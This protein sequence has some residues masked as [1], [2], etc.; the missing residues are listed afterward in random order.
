SLTKCI[1]EIRQ[2]LGPGLRGSLRTLVGRGYML[3]GWRSDD[4]GRLLSGHRGEG[5]GRLPEAR[6]LVG[7]EPETALGVGLIGRERLVTS[8][9]SGGVGKASL[10]IAAANRVAADFPDGAFL[11]QLAPLLPEGSVAAAILATRR[12]AATGDPLRAL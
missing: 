1:S 3:T 4:S 6:R 7:R 9:G 2:A 8:T 12:I 10:A 5:T 11:V